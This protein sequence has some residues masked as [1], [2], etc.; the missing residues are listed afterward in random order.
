MGTNFEIFAHRGACLKTKEENTISAFSRAQQWGCAGLELDVRLT[1]DDQL[2][3]NH[4]PLLRRPCGQNGPVV[5]RD[6]SWADLRRE[7]LTT[8]LVSE[9]ETNLVAPSLE[10]VLD[11]F[12][13]RL[14][15]NIELK[16]LHSASAL[17]TLLIKKSLFLHPSLLNNI[18]ISSFLSEE[19]EEARKILPSIEIGALV[20]Y[21]VLTYQFR[22]WSNFL[23]WAKK[24]ATATIHLNQALA[25]KE[26]V[27]MLKYQHGLTVRV[28]TVNDFETALTLKSLGVDG[29][30]TDR[31]ETLR[32]LQGAPL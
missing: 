9:S 1:K 16:D 11:L 15:I 21:P 28:F 7:R 26:T 5:I 3:V 32:S 29:V 30:F 27:V 13:G 6:H 23:S 10:L 14:K 20:N 18:I 17:Q 24:N 8:N 4:D 19:L 2:I 31:V 12:L 22:G 25:S